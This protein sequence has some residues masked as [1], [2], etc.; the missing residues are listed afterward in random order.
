V[1]QLAAALQAAAE[2]DT[3]VVGEAIASA[4]APSFVL[5]PLGDLPVEGA[6]ASIAGWRLV[7][8]HPAES[9]PNPG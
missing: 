2:P 5:Q 7:G 6:P 4:L 8:P 9:G 1:V 3:I